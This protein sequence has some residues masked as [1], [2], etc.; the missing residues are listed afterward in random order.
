MDEVIIGFD[1]GVKEIL[2]TYSKNELLMI[3]DEEITKEDLLKRMVHNIMENSDKVDE[4]NNFL[5]NIKERESIGSTGIGMGVAMPHARFQGVKG[6]VLSIA[7]V[8]NGVNFETPDGERV[9]L[10]VMVGAPMEQGKQYLTLIA[11]I[12]RIFRNNEY[13]EGIINAGSIPQLRKRLEE[14][15]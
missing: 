6:I 7:I 4:E 12:A 13:R 5:D 15:R 10:V 14:F 2:D 11:A 8:K 1:N 3:I 9:R